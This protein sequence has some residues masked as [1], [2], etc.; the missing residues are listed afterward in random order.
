MAAWAVPHSIAG[1]RAHSSHHRGLGGGV[2]F[3]F[4]ANQNP[5]SV[6]VCE[7]I[8]IYRR[9]NKAQRSRALEYDEVSR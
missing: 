9:A 8:D 4:M 5:L 3:G 1:T 6:A 2:E 7:G